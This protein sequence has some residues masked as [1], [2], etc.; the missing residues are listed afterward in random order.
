MSILLH[1]IIIICCSYIIVIII[2]IIV[3]SSQRLDKEP[4]VLS[5]RNEHDNPTIHLKNLDAHTLRMHVIKC[6]N[7]CQSASCHAETCPK[8]LV[9]SLNFIWTIC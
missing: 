9:T 6:L 2:I 7:W 5:V 1:H 8:Y 3:L 4:E